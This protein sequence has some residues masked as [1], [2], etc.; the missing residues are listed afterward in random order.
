MVFVNG[1]LVQPLWKPSTIPNMWKQPKGPLTD[2]WI[3]MWCVCVYTYIHTKEYYS[4]I[5]RNEIMPF[6]VTWMDLEI[7][8]PNELNQIV[9]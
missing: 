4:A 1:K 7:I 9:S 2:E 8:I 6:T 5:K 3:K